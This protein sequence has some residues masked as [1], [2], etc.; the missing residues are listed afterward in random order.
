MKPLQLNCRRTFLFDINYFIQHCI[1]HC[2]LH[3]FLR[4][5]MWNH[6]QDFEYKDM[7]SFYFSFFSYAAILSTTVSSSMLA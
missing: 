4:I 6:L 2:I 7:R 5:D 1:P 3:I